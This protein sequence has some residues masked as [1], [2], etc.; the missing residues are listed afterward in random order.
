MHEPIGVS[1]PII[2][3]RTFIMDLVHAAGRV[4]TVPVSRVFDV[5]SLFDARNNHP[6]RPSWS[7][8]FMKAFGIVAAQNPLMRRAL[9]TIPWTRLYEHPQST[10]A[11]AIEREY[12][13]E[14]GIFV[15][16]FRAP[17]AQTLWDLQEALE[18]YKYQP[19]EEV[20]LYRLMLRVSRLPK[21]ARRFAWWYALNASGVK[22]AKRLGTFGLSSYGSL[23][24]ESLHPISPLTTT[25]TYG[26]IDRNGQVNVKLIYD[27]R[28]LDGAYVARRLHDIEAALQGPILE[29]LV[30]ARRPA[31]T[32][33]AMSGARSELYAHANGR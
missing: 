26:P 3:T 2:E 21:P 28:V 24:A 25:L 19:V 17:E 11:L 9:L 23:G 1:V 22:R 20:G 32:Q 13:S 4:P 12:K 16:L 29:E 5:R 15:G 14:P 33:V 10:C 31:P 6:R 27:H 8:L 30:E 18:V 7:V